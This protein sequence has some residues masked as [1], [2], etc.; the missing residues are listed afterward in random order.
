MIH[1]NTTGR[2]LIR[3]YYCIIYIT[4]ISIFTFNMVCMVK[5]CL[6]DC[7]TLSTIHIEVDAAL[8]WPCPLTDPS[9]WQLSTSSTTPPYHYH[10]TS[11]PK[12]HH[13]TTTPTT[14]LQLN[15]CAICP[16]NYIPRAHLW[17]GR[18]SVKLTRL[19][20]SAEF[21]VCDVGFLQWLASTPSRQE[22]ICQ[23]ARL[24][25]ASYFTCESWQLKPMCYRLRG[26]LRCF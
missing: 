1:Y 3:W 9:S 25:Y 18:L 15:I 5:A 16:T 21:N 17:A 22:K 7:K 19:Q 12:P 24:R 14:P 23:P 26:S 11:P 8:L 20:P 6:G 2:I 13:I 4:Y 10:T